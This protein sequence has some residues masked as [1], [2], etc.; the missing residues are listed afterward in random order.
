MNPF[1]NLLEKSGDEQVLPPPNGQPTPAVLAFQTKKTPAQRQLISQKPSEI[2][3]FLVDVAY[4][5]Y[6]YYDPVTGRWPSRDPIE[7]RGGDNLYA[8]VRYGPGT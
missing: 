8:F 1:V 5:G 4:Y 3:D 2:N 7:E 6:R